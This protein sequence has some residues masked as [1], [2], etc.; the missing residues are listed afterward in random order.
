MTARFETIRTEGKDI[1]KLMKDTV[2]TIRPD[3]KSP[4]WLDY[5]NYINGLVIEGITNGIH[6]SMTYLAK[7]IDIKLNQ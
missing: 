6:S 5:Q 7:Q 2:D 3:K 1:H 4:E